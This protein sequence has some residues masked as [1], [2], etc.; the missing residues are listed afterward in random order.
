MAESCDQRGTCSVQY[1]VEAD[2]SVYPCDFY[3]LD[4]CRLGNFNTDHLERI[5]AARKA[6]GFIERSLKLDEMCRTCRYAPLCRGGCQRHR[7]PVPGTER[8]RNYFCKGYQLFF[9]ES[10]D[11]LMELGTALAKARR[12]R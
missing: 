12:V 6:S 8:Y 5:D 10:Y 11:K 9:E 4:A 7:E 2:G 3:M 1:V